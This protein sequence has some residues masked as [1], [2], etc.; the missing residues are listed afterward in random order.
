M[1]DPLTRY[2]ISRFTSKTVSKTSAIVTQIGRVMWVVAT[3]GLVV[4]VPLVWSLNKEGATVFES[5]LDVQKRGRELLEG[6]KESTP[7]NI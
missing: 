4:G 5:D 6:N 7:F 3:T 1:V 2:H